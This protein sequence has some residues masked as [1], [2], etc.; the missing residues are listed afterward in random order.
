MN[1][2]SRGSRPDR[3]MRLQRAIV[4]QLLCDDH[5]AGWSLQELAAELVVDEQVLQDAVARLHADGVVCASAAEV[6]AS[7]AARRLDEL[8]LVAI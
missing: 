1:T 3:H 4:L 8:E 2:Q 7:R 6:Q 5:P